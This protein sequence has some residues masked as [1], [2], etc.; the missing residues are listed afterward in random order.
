MVCAAIGL[1]PGG[2]LDGALPARVEGA[3]FHG[4]V[5]VLFS[6]ALQTHD[7]FPAVVERHAFIVGRCII[8]EGILGGEYAGDRSS[9]LAGIVAIDLM[10]MRGFLLC[11]AVEGALP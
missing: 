10:V 4:I 1:L 2:L 6:A 9:R 8:A 3:L 11:R 7:R 5:P